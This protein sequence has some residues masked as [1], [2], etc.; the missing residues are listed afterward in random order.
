MMRTA[1]DTVKSYS[2]GLISRALYDAAG[3]IGEI[4]DP[5]RVVIKKFRRLWLGMV[6]IRRIFSIHFDG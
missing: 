5:T 3:S 2:L 1:A 6:S 4:C